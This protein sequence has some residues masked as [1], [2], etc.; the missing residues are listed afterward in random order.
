MSPSKKPPSPARSAMGGILFIAALLVLMLLWRGVEVVA[1]WFWFQEVG[2]ETIFSVT[3]LNQL[4]VG[5]FFGVAFFIIFYLNLYLATRF[6][7]QG[8]WVDR[9][10]LIH[11]PPW[12]SGTQ[13]IGTLVLLASLLFSLFAA[14]RGSAQWENYLRFLYGTPFGTADPLFN[15]D[16]GFYVFQLPFLK[17]LYGWLMTVLIITIL[18][19]GVVYFIRRSFQF[20]P[21]QT[22][23]IAPAARKH[24]I[25]LGACLF[26]VGTWGAWI[27]LY[28]MLYSKRGVVFGPGYT[29]VN[30][31]LLMLKVLIVVTALCGLT[32]L[33]MLFRRDWKVP[34]VGVGAFLAVLI[35]GTGNLPVSGPEIQSNPRRD[36]PGEALPGKEYSIHPYGLRVELHQGPGIPR[37]G[38][39]DPGRPAPQRADH[40]EH[41]PL[42]SCSRSSPPT[43]SS[44]KSAPTTNLST[45]TTTGTPST[46]SY[47]QVMLSARELS[48]R[49][50]PSRTWVNEHLTYTHGYGAVLG[51]VNRISPEGLP[52]FF[53]KDIPPVSSGEIKIT[54]PEIYYGETSNEYVFVRGKRPEFDYPVGEKNVYS[55]YQGKGGV[56]LSFLRKVLFAIRFGAFNILLSDELTG[57]SR[58]MYY[59]K[60]QDRV[61]RAAPFIH[62]DPDSYLVISTEGRLLWILDGYTTTD[63]F[64]YS[65]PI[66]NLGNYI[67][68]SVKA[69][70]D[71]YDGTLSLYISRPQGPDHPNVCPDVPRRAQAPGGDARRIAKAHPLSPGPPLHPGPNVLHLPHA[72]RPGL[73]QQGRPLEHPAEGRGGPDRGA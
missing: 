42:G 1:D 43:A 48:Y 11:I 61:S 30:T 56:P 64:P 9:D 66:G 2:Y 3:L 33:S 16:I 73:L 57:D 38:Y 72:G 44:R 63:R 67:R 28:E 49:A 58:I 13:P 41:P 26:F 12:E 62:L 24:L 54:R 45:W 40:Q 36:R 47:R 50:L 34:A 6:S 4:K 53:I 59:R 5:A 51:P 7:S 46:A 8:Y 60:I 21:P 29:D 25:V 70:V 17:D 19:T 69:V 68:N 35:I 18:G 20:I 27:A 23:R 65:E 71:A 52:E 37:R 39:P 10:D 22:L 15:R 55:Q 14:L 31:Q 32:I